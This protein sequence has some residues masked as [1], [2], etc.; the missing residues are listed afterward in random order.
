MMLGTWWHPSRHLGILVFPTDLHNALVLHRH[1]EKRVMVLG[2][3]EV[4]ISTKLAM[5]TIG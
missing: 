2:M 5:G 1:W 3:P 4:G